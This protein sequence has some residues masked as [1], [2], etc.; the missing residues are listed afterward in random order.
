MINNYLVTVRRVGDNNYCCNCFEDVEGVQIQLTSEE[1]ERS[2]LAKSIFDWMRMGVLY[3]MRSE[4][5]FIEI[6]SIER[7]VTQ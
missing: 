2:P 7:V 5:A 6:K 4:K 3:L 1:M